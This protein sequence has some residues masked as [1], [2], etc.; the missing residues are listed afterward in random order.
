[1]Q[2]ARR[3]MKGKKQMGKF[4]D[5][6]KLVLPKGTVNRIQERGVP[7]ILDW[8]VEQKSIEVVRCKDC[9][10]HGERN[11]KK[12][13]TRLEIAFPIMEDEDFCSKGKRRDTE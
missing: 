4:I 3:G 5:M 13:C 10:Y 9:I 2:S 8:L 12:C 11:N 1:M 6:D 7:A